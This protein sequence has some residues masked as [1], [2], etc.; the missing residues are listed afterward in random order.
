MKVPATR[1]ELREQI[2]P[3]GFNAALFRLASA[4]WTAPT[5]KFAIGA[6]SLRAIDTGTSHQT[7]ALRLR[8]V[9]FA[10]V[11]LNHFPTTQHSADGDQR[12][13]LLIE[14]ADFLKRHAAAGCTSAAPQ[15]VIRADDHGARLTSAPKAT[16]A[17]PRRAALLLK[18]IFNHLQPAEYGA[19][20]NEGMAF[21]S[22]DFSYG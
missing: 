8:I 20:W 16:S 3:H 9:G 1:F 12:K 4:G 22:R 13:S 17:K 7:S 11:V 15:M 5:S 14:L 2:I 6:D 18:I 21:I 10:E 19:D